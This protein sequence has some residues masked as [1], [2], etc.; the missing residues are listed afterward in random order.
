M[1]HFKMATSTNES[2]RTVA[3]AKLLPWV[4]AIRDGHLTT[5]IDTWKFLH[6]YKLQAKY[7]VYEYGF[8]KASD[9]TFAEMILAGF[10]GSRKSF[11]GF[12]KIPPETVIDYMRLFLQ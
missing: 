4:M 1:E 12:K 6:S 2:D 8:L 9:N 3:T 5:I 10:I 7:F 11:L